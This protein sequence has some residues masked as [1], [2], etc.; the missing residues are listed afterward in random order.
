M[1][2]VTSPTPFPCTVTIVPPNKISE[3]SPHFVC[4]FCQH[5]SRTTFCALFS[6]SLSLSLSL[7]GVAHLYRM[8][9][10]H[11]QTIYIFYYMAQ[12]T[13]SHL[14]YNTIASALPPLLSVLSVFCGIFRNPM[15]DFSSVSCSSLPRFFSLS[16]FSLNY[17]IENPLRPASKRPSISEHLFRSL[18]THTHISL[19]HA[20][21]SLRPSFGSFVWLVWFCHYNC[22]RFPPFN[23]G[24]LLLRTCHKGSCSSSEGGGAGAAGEPVSN[25]YVSISKMLHNK[26]FYV[27]ACN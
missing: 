1:W 25:K 21:L 3:I 2:G 16:V 23:E 10:I 17:C 8:C 9:T 22:L 13:L 18:H 19:I 27:P 15:N 20:S 24:P 7:S 12:G 4:N 14:P 6:L 11:T 5:V 26:H